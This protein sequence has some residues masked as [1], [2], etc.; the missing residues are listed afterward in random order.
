[1]PETMIDQFIKSRRGD[2]KNQTAVILNQLKAHYSENQ[3][4]MQARVLVKNLVN[5]GVIPEGPALS[6]LLGDLERGKIIERCEK[7]IPS[8]RS[9]PDKKKPS[10]FYRISHLAYL[11]NSSP[12]KDTVHAMKVY[13]HE[14]QL[15]LM[16]MKKSL[17][18][19]G[20]LDEVEKIKMSDEFIRYRKF[21]DEYR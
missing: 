21:I 1:M 12:S 15:A 2:G 3:G 17:E 11:D 16:V 19:H 13:M 20:L 8:K 10:V 5:T 6:R 18:N 14:Q 9:K 4:W 7:V